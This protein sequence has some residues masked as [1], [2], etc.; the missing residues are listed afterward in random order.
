MDYAI[1]AI[2][3]QE[4]WD[5]WEHNYGANA[6]MALYDI[7]MDRLVAYR[8]AI[9]AGFYTDDVRAQPAPR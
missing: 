9:L 6:R 7:D 3:D 2:E 1:T 5:A 4:I 8:R